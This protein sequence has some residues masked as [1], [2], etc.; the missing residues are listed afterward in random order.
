MILKKMVKTNGSAYL[1]DTSS[2][3]SH[4][5]GIYCDIWAVSR[6][7]IGKYVAAERLILGN[8]LVTEHVLHEYENWKL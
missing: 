1:N 5:V 3:T 7:R 4:L 2:S 6:K 8:Q